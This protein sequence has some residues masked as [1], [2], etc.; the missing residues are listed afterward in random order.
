MPIVEKVSA[1]ARWKK[2][3]DTFCERS[4]WRAE[5]KNERNH[6]PS[7]AWHDQLGFTVGFNV[8]KMFKCAM[9]GFSINLLIEGTESS[10]KLNC[11]LV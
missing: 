9:N 4:N 8:T 5:L 7:F 1:P 6:F 11:G 2:S 3:L 10:M